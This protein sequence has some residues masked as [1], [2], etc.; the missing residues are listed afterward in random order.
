ML[1][2]V[3]RRVAD[4]REVRLV[5]LEDVLD[6]RVVPGLPVQALLDVRL[7][8]DDAG[9]EDGEVGRRRGREL[10]R[11]V[12][13]EVAG[14]ARLGATSPA[15]VAFARATEVWKRRTCERSGVS[16]STLTSRPAV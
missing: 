12:L 5:A 6:Q 15:S 3:R 14:E 1:E 4:H 16:V 2:L 10:L 7:L 13:R 9:L 11:D 8:A